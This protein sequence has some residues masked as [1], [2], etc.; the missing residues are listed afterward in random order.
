[1]PNL[2]YFDIRGGRGEPARAPARQPIHQS[3][4]RG[5]PTRPRFTGTGTG[6]GTGLVEAV[7]IE[8]ASDHLVS[9]DSMAITRNGLDAETPLN[10]SESV[11]PDQLGTRVPNSRHADALLVP[12]R[13]AWGVLRVV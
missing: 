10:P 6:T 9:H 3:S 4:L 5:R 2:T 7:G 11:L 8:P 12:V 13:R 1:M